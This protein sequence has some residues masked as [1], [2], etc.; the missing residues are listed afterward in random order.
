LKVLLLHWNEITQPGAI[1]I[2]NAL[3][4]NKGLMVLD[5]SF[6]NIGNDPYYITTK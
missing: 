1:S 5:I 3:E 4:I 6:N 2:S